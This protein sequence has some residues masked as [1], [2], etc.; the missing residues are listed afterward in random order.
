[1]L[2]I[3]HRDVSPSNIMVCRD[4]SVKL[5]DFGVAKV[6]G[7]APSPDLTRSLKGK[8]A[9]MAPGQ[10]NH[11]PF[12]RRADVFAAGIVLHEMLTGKRLFGRRSE[13]ETLQRVVAAQ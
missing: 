8:F 9:Y 2:E 10:V 12:D 4:G 13:H 1:R 5:L 7:A 3:V 6:V 11:K